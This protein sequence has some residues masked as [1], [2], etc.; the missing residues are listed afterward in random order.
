MPKVEPSDSSYMPSLVEVKVGHTVGGLK[1]LKKVA[2]PSSS[3]EAILLTGMTEVTLQ[4]SELETSA[5]FNH[6]KILFWAPH[7]LTDFLS[8]KKELW[9]GFIVSHF[10]HD[11]IFTHGL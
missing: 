7:T 4:A 8:R 3:R 1:E 2:I 10:I 11:S 6:K 9:K 5:K